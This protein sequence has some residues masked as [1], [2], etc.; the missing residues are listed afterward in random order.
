MAEHNI[1]NDWVDRYIRDELNAEEEVAF[2]E[3]LLEDTG[4]QQELEAALAIKET[5]QRRELMTGN[6][7]EPPASAVTRNSWTPYAM[8]ASVLLAV[9]STTLLWRANIETNGLKQQLEALKQPRTS[10]LNVPV[11]IMRSAGNTT[12][13]VIIQKP[14]MQGVIVLDVELSPRFSQ[15]DQINFELSG[16]AGEQFLAWRSSPTPDGRAS[17][18]LNSEIIPDGR[19]ILAMS[20]PGTEQKETRLLE[21]RPYV[22]E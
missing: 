16:E 19:V 7:V 10:V 8:A 20:S 21:F 4:L 17:V 2:E 3:R 13:D 15:L 9:A 6:V 1:N 12:P 18:V 5:L 14:G 22:K 11:D